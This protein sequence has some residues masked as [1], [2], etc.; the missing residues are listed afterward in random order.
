MR[1]QL[2]GLWHFYVSSTPELVNLYQTDEV[3]T[4]EVPNKLQVVEKDH[5]FSFAQED[6]WK[7]KLM[8]KFQ[9]E[10]NFC[11]GGTE[12]EPQHV[13]GTWSTIYDQAFQIQLDNG[14]RFL[15]NFRYSLKD[16]TPAT[17]TAAEFAAMASLKTGDYGKFNS[18]CDKSM[19]GFVQTIPS[20]SN[21]VYSLTNH[22][23]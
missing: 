21:E 5:Q 10:A 20:L 2:Y 4:H 13:T 18:E 8:D 22:K 15:A 1:G 17:A 19:I 16:Y 14:L 12:C 23:V 6:L 9:V 7:V 11:K 3:C